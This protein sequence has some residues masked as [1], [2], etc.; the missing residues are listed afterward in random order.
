MILVV[1]LLPFVSVGRF[2]I[3][4]FSLRLAVLIYCCEFVVG[5]HTERKM[6]LPMNF[7]GVLSMTLAI[8]LNGAQI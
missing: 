4:E 6:L 7:A 8:I 2:A 5:K 1:P 3:G